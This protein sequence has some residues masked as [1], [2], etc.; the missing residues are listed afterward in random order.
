MSANA[1]TNPIRTQTSPGPT[2]SGPVVLLGRLLFALIFLMSGPRHFMSSTI[3]YARTGCAHGFDRRACLRID[4]VAR[5]SF[6]SAGLSR[7]NRSLAHRSLSCGRYA[8]VAQILGNF[9][10]HGGADAD[11]KFHEECFHAGRRAAHHSIR[12]RAVEP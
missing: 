9:R 11:G 2:V 8:H 4:R 5:R 10:S 6:H 12:L 3:A 1:L 7:Q